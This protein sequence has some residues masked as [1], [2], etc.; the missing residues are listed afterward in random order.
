MRLHD[1]DPT[2]TDTQVLDFCKKGFLMLEAVVGDDINRRTVEFVENRGSEP[3]EILEQDWFM[4]NVILQPD[5]AGAVRSL[6]GRDFGLPV[7]VSNH[8]V[9]C[10]MPRQ[11]WHRDGNS[12]HGPALKYLQV[13]YYPQEVPREMGP[14]EVLPGSHFLY[15]NGQLPQNYMGHYGGI[16]GSHYTTAPAGT[17]FLTVYSIWHR[18]SASTGSG[19]RNNL[20][21]NYFRTDDAGA[22]L[23]PRGGLR[24]RDRGLRVRRASHLSPAASG[25]HR[26]R[27]DVLLAV[28]Q[29]EEEFRVLG[30]QGWPVPNSDNHA[31]IAPPYGVPEGLDR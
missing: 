28:R 6:L 1:C 5:A 20:K 23:D 18:R 30:G 26:Q 31:L 2:M 29:V 16:R 9:T 14:T 15:T 24:L 12:P 13:F 22:G 11:Q 21:Y 7:L 19:V 25:H 4:D 27:G 8:R 3:S 17:I 10:P